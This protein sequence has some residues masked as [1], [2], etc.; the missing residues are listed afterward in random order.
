MNLFLFKNYHSQNAEW[1]QVVPK[2]NTE[3]TV[4]N[5]NSLF[6]KSST[7]TLDVN[8]PL[9]VKEN[10]RFFGN[11]NRHDVQQNKNARWN[12]Q[13]IVNGK[14]IIVGESILTGVNEQE[15]TVQIL[16]GRSV[17]N[18]NIGE[19]YIDELNIGKVVSEHRIFVDQYDE[20]GQYPNFDHINENDILIQD[21][22]KYTYPE[23]SETIQNKIAF[24]RDGTTGS[25]IGGCKLIKININNYYDYDHHHGCYFFPIR[26]S[27]TGF[28]YNLFNVKEATYTKFGDSFT[29]IKE[30]LP[31]FSINKNAMFATE[32]G[33]VMDTESNFCMAPQLLL[34]EAL[35]RIFK[36]VGYTIDY[37]AMP[38]MFKDA[39]IANS[40]NTQ[41]LAKTLP[42]WTINELIGEIEKLFCCVFVIDAQNKQVTLKRK[43]EYVNQSANVEIVQVIDEF[44]T[45]I[46]KQDENSE[47][48][49]IGNCGYNY[50]ETDYTKWEKIKQEYKDMCQIKIFDNETQWRN[51][52]DADILNNVSWNK[53]YNYLG[54]YWYYKNGGGKQIID[55]FRD[56]INNLT[57]REISLEY[58]I[59][60]AQHNIMTLLGHVRYDH[61]LNPNVSYGQSFSQNEI[62]ILESEGKKVFERF[63]WFQDYLEGGGHYQWSDI[64]DESE[65][66]DFNL[67]NVIEGEDEFVGKKEGTTDTMSLFWT[68]ICTDEG[69]IELM[70]DTYEKENG[71]WYQT[72]HYPIGKVRLPFP[73]TDADTYDNAYSVP[74]GTD[75]SMCLEKQT[76]HGDSSIGDIIVRNP[77]IDTTVEYNKTIYS[78]V[79]I[80]ENDILLINGKR[81]LAKSVT[82]KIN[83]EGISP[84]MECVLY[85]L[86]D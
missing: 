22:I 67:Q 27:A 6:T 17:F 60:P 81:Y 56:R 38:Q 40:T 34:V 80:N 25:S 54:N 15:I 66:Y 62:F 59:I 85:M 52:F 77:I 21:E 43:H 49:N 7:Y 47:D 84:L 76:P 64:Y 71:N 72:E 53:I 45:T 69:T 51:A 70:N 30:I 28:T 3:I 18:N 79:K 50:P 57:N 55:Q 39:V 48:P 12:V 11:I 65:T 4:V 20:V 37:S 2:K 75:Y 46:G 8:F 61:P 36:A 33:D 78:K 14:P 9:D 73:Y 31:V 58:K 5:E 24:S 35:K 1:Q 42:H 19:L 41:F 83:D 16:S 74:C 63:I 23:L 86:E 32:H 44:N 82:Y 26:N 10:A 29:N 68:K 13:V